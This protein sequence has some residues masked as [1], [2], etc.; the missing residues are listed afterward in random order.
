MTIGDCIKEVSHISPSKDDWIVITYKS[1]E[2]VQSLLGSLKHVF[3]GKKFLIIQEGISISSLDDSTLASV[4]LK[5][6]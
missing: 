1:G 6:A 3:P 2:R 4:G 5:R